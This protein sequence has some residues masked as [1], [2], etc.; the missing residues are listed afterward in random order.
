M[1]SKEDLN[2]AI[3]T[4][5]QKI[6]GVGE[7]LADYGMDITAAISKLQADVTAGADVSESI[8]AL[9]ALAAKVDE[10]GETIKG[11]DVTVEGISGQPTPPVA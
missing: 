11:L 1:A 5:S 6:T 8:A 7:L 4:L 10:A 2:A 3:E 9:T